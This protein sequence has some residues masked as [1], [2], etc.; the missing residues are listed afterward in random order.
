MKERQTTWM[1]SHPKGVPPATGVIQM[2]LLSN[3]KAK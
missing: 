1:D 2:E 3:T